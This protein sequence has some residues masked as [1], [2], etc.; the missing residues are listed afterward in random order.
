MKPFSDVR[1]YFLVRAPIFQRV[2]KHNSHID[3]K[4]VPKITSLIPEE[5]MRVFTRNLRKSEALVLTDRY[6]RGVRNKLLHKT[7]NVKVLEGLTS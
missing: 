1:S 4:H 3:R 2:I 5:A 7:S 6:A